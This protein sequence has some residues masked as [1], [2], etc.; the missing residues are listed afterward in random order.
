VRSFED[1]WEGG[2]QVYVDWMRDR[3]I[4]LHRIL[5]PTGSLYLHCDWHASHYRKVMCDDIFRRENFRNEI[6]WK[7]TSGH[8]DARRAGNVHDVMLFYSKSDTYTWNAVVQPYDEGYVDAYY[9]YKDENGR[10]FMSD[11]LT[12]AG[13][14]PE[15]DFGARGVLKPPKGRHWMYDQAGITRM[16]S[17]N[18][19]YWTKNG[20]PR[21]KAYLDEARGMPLQDVWTDVQAL[22]SWHK[23][24][25]GYPTQKPVALLE[26]VLSAS[27]NQGDVVLDPF[28]GC[29][30]TLVAAQRLTRQWVGIDI[31]PT[32]VMIM[33]ERLSLIGAPSVKLVG[34]PVTE[35]QLRALKPYEF[36]NWVIQRMHGSHSPRKSGDMGIDGFSFMLHEPIQVK[37]WGDNVGRPEIDKFETAVERTGKAKGYV[38][39]F[40]F[41][42]GAYEEAARVK[43]SKGLDI[44]LVKVGDLLTDAPDIV[45][46]QPGLFTTDLPLPEARPAEARPSVEELIASEHNGN[47]LARA[48]EL[49]ESY[50]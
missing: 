33:K 10:R 13:S 36:Q 45:T 9:R 48:A 5:K 19:L 3:I 17:E 2:I 1:R 14:G 21:V 40:S 18:R 4:E 16:I 49:P 31:S 32:A 15:R 20:I 11:N 46:P 43:A 41:T 35:D 47:E 34:M 7:R 25:L 42:K 6:I 22:R 23:E 39:A 24:G 30:T 27:S 8:S 38:V 44:V 50:G 37:R 29:G 26:R 12:G 28:C